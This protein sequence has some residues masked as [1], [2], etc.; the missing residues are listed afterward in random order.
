MVLKEIV[1]ELNATRPGK[2]E[3]CLR[4]IR[5]EMDKCR[6]LVIVDEA[7]LLEMRILE[8]IRNLNEFA[9]CPVLLIGESELARKIANRKR[10]E[11]RIRRSMTFSPVSQPDVALFYKRALGLDLGPEA[12]R[13]LHRACGGDWRPVM[14]T[15]LDIERALTASGSKQVTPELVVEI[16][17]RKAA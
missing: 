14:T 15:A 10:L 8:M 7:D 1:F 2:T 4:A 11:S 6:R 5:E 13:S 16:L 17:G 3:T 9:R 12:V